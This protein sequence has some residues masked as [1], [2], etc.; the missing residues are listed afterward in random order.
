MQ[1]VS[2]IE[3]TEK[4]NKQTKWKKEKKKTRSFFFQVI[5]SDTECGQIS[6]WASN[7]AVGIHALK[8]EAFQTKCAVAL[9]YLGSC[10]TKQIMH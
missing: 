3:A 8:V 5:K 4:R 9:F 10:E 2:R 1:S 7:K 6:N